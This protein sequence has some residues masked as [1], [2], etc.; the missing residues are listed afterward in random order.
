MS[1]QFIP[2][3][4]SGVSPLE[5]A[6]ECDAYYE[7]PKGADGAR[8]GPLAAYAGKYDD[9][10]VQKQ[11][12]GEKFVNFAKIERFPMIVRDHIVGPLL[13]KL[14]PY[15]EDPVVF[16]PAPMGG[17]ALGNILALESAN[18]YGFPEKMQLEAATSSGRA[19]SKLQYGRHEVRRGSKIILV[20]DV[21]NNF[22]TTGEFIELLRSLGADVLAITCF[23][24]RS[25]THD[26]VFEHQGTRYP[27]VALWREA[28]DEWRQDDPAVAA[29][30]ANENV[31]W[32]PKL[33]WDELKDAMARAA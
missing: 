17:L 33:V 3:L 5:I 16:A 23:L 18:E 21:C 20:E 4:R 15:L 32:Q 14:A 31:R 7:C 25:M 28:M 11:Y 12:V 27:I 13:K 8:L 29:D 30:I 1:L 10:G 2:V 19:V 6:Q 9:Q 26:D 22:S 24:N